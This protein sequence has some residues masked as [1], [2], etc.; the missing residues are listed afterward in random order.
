MKNTET[1]QSESTKTTR[2]KIFILLPFK[3]LIDPK[4]S[5]NICFK[6]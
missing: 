2:F 5:S 3:R 1:T 4:T 6:I